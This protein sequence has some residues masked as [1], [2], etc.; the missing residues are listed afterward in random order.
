MMS[1]G[2]IS[3]NTAES[4]GGVYLQG[5]GT[6]TMSGGEISD[7]T[8]EYGGGVYSYGTFT[9]SD[10]KISG[11]TAAYGE[12]G[13]GG[14]GGGVY[15]DYSSTF[16]MSDGEISGNTAA[17]YGGGVYVDGSGSFTKTDGPGIIYG[18]NIEEALKHLRN[19]ASI[20]GNAVYHES[21]PAKIRD[22]T[23]KADEALSSASAIGWE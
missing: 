2:K 7:N 16:M 11:N 20:G 5:S 12:G 6:F 9:M 23:I 21:S 19:T 22:V 8:A 18:S 1:D 3:D 13:Y 17:Q 15:V 14:Y 10:G 4:G